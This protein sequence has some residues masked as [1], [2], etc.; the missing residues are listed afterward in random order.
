MSNA[1]PKIASVVDTQSE[2]LR[3]DVQNAVLVLAAERDAL[4]L[5]RGGLDGELGIRLSQA[6]DVLACL[7]GRLIVTG[8]GKSGHIGRKLAATFAST[9]TPAHF[10]HPADASHG[11][12]GMIG[13]EDVVM[14]LSWSGESAELFDIVAYTRRYRVPLIA[15]TS[16]AD[17]AL[18]MAAD[19]AL[20]LPDVPEACPN[21]LA[22]TTSTTA[23][24]V[25]GDALAI[26]LLSRR[27]FSPQ[28]F[29]QFHP[30]GRLGAR[31]RQV[32]DLMHKLPDV[33]LVPS[34]C[35]LTS[36]ILEMT[37]KRFGVTGVVDDAGKLAGVISDGD[38]RRAFEKGFYDRPAADVMSRNPRVIAPEALAQQALGRL[39]AERITSLF[40]LDDDGKPTG[41]ITVHDLLQ[42]GIS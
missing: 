39:N 1:I 28:D 33:P 25:L 7:K 6:V 15:I 42:A 40:I 18:G 11:D 35:S 14:A 38:L 36:A 37:S 13:S 3:Q 5:L 22:P 30:G 4:D 32:R 19:I 17:S 8:I 27:H 41:I 31:L 23:Q 29:M 24:L 10:V 20:I 21:G 9:G 26:C 16:R 34:E 2:S 12:L